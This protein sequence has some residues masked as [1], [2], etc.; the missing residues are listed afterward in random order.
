MAIATAPDKNAVASPQSSTNYGAMA[1]V[2]T[3]FFAWGFLT[4]LND[5]L[6]PHLKSIFDLNYAKS[7][8]VQF[9]FFG[10]YFVFSFPSGKIIDY[11]G[12]KKAM[13]IGL[14]TMGVGA[15]LFVPAASI[16]SYPLFLAALI[17]LAAGMTV[18]QT[19]ANPYV[20]VLGPPKT[21]SSRLNLTQAFNSFGTFIAP[22]V[23]SA[24]ILGMVAAPIA[25]DQLRKLP[26]DQLQL[27]RVTQ[28]ASV[29]VPYIGFAIAL[30]VLAI[31]IA[32]FKLPKIQSVEARGEQHGSIWQYRHL[33]LGAVGI[34]VYVGAEV[35]IGSFLTNYL[36]TPEIGGLTLEAAAKMLIY[37]WGGAMV[38]RFVG[39]AL[40]QKIPTGKLLAFNAL[41]A[42]LLV[43]T[44]M[45]TTGHVAMWSIL[46]VGLFNSIM[47]PSIFTL[48]IE[49]LGP[50]TGDGSGLLVAAIVG[51]AIVPLLQG[52]IADRIG[53]HHAFFLPAICYLYI[54]YFGLRGSIPRKTAVAALPVKA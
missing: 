54:V 11:L 46:L 17:I 24:L 36:N 6:I 39:S 14:I 44:T 19:S 45:V 41:V 9:A 33:V 34:F 8:L 27:Y 53:I 42:S 50:L 48:A 10:A 16:A 3:L 7:M 30:F 12:Y 31:V 18:L 22:Y 35:S 47:F 20:A 25:A 37:Y 40:L 21:A 52:F 43:V 29:K 51:G 1:M 5:I 4:C 23:G 13:V 28:A 38:G 15:I 2:T 32:L 26:A 49:G